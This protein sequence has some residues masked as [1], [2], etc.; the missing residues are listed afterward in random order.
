MHEISVNGRVVTP[1]EI[2]AEAAH[3]AE[4]QDPDAAAARALVV[5]ELLRERIVA[6][7][8][9]EGA[10]ADADAFDDAVDELLAREAPVPEPTDAECRR[11]YELDRERFRRGEL[12]EA[13]HILFA[14]TPDSPVDAIRRQAEATLHQVVAEPDRFGEFAQK[15]SNCPSGAQGGNLGQLQRGDVVPEF[16][17]A[18]F[19]GDQAGETGVLP[20]LVRTRYGFHIV[21]VSHRV[22]GD[23]VPYETAE[24]VLRQMLVERVRA[25]AA[26]QYVRVLAG[27][28]KIVGVTLPGADTPLLQ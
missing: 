13:A 28:A 3:Y 14:I 9:G 12:V 27:Q 24:P 19:E 21:L 1:Q 17:T 2:A 18:V 16:A 20:R 26:E 10:A 8:I 6:L 25:K 5:R 4:L 22:A 15:F 23:I 11:L 7:G